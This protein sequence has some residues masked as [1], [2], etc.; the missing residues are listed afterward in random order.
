[1]VNTALAFQV[2]SVA[3]LVIVVVAWRWHQGVPVNVRLSVFRE[4]THASQSCFEKN[5]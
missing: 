4:K 3:A 1:V 5:V 2:A